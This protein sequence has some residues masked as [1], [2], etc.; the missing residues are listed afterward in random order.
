MKEY[1]EGDIAFE[2]HYIPVEVYINLRVTAKA[3][4]FA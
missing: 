1:F 2:A 3:R 4:S